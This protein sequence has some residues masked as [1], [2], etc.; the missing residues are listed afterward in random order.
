MPIQA[1]VLPPS[2]VAE[3]ADVKRRLNSLERKPKLGSVNERLPYSSYQTQPVTGA[4]NTAVWHTLGA[5]NSTGLNQPVLVCGLPFSIPQGTSGPLDVS[6]TVYL[7]EMLTGAQSARVTLSQTT[8]HPATPGLTQ[9]I[10]WAWRHPQPVGFD[11][12]HEWKGFAVDYIVNRRATDPTGTSVTVNLGAP[13]LITGVPLGTFTEEA[14][15]GNPRI[16][17]TLTPANGGPVTWTG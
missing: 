10:T 6:V 8:D 9:L 3:L 2:L 7:R 13:V 4:A 16:R 11:D 1:N 14:A 15:D 5:V 12:A 17:G